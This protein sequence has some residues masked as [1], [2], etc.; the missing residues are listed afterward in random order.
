[1]I[2][3]FTALLYFGMIRR[4]AKLTDTNICKLE[5]KMLL[6]SGIFSIQKLASQT[7]RKHV[8]PSVGTCLED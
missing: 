7:V 4:K 8:N 6:V 3:T 1:M 2:Y 5:V